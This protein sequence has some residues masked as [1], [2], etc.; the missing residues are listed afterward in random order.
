MWGVIHF[1]LLVAMYKMGGY[2]N[3]QLA[4]TQTFLFVMHNVTCLFQA[5]VAMQIVL[6]TCFPYS[7]PSFKHVEHLAVC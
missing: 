5:F 4:L 7:F 6:S 1:F 2:P 3:S